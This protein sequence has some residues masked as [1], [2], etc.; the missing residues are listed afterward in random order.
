MKKI[1]FLFVL[2]L[3]FVLAGC[4]KLPAYNFLGKDP[5]KGNLIE[6]NGAIYRSQ[7]ETAWRPLPTG[8]KLIGENQFSSGN[9]LK[10][11]ISMFIG[12]LDRIFVME[13]F[14]NNE[15]FREAFKE[16]YYYR[17]DVKLPPYDRSGVNMLGFKKVGSFSKYV[18]TQNKESIDKIFELKDNALIASEGGFD[19]VYELQLMN[20][21]YTGIGI[22]VIVYQKN[23]TYW[24]FF[25]EFMSPI[26]QEFLEQIA[27][28]KLPE[29]SGYPT[30]TAG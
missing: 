27:G 13:T 21:N 30:R 2:L 8:L 17:E 3:L 29:A 16:N 22:K 18:F 10:S 9:N 14:S 12:D 1:I 28:E 15:M 26:S 20:S 7:P 5:V 23:N 24:I 4:E 6:V 19:S 11:H 25:N